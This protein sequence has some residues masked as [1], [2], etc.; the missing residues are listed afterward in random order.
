MTLTS[1]ARAQTVRVLGVAVDRE[2]VLGPSH[3]PQGHSDAAA[4]I[5]KY[6]KR[7]LDNPTARGCSGPKS[8]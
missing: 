6:T 8:K 7:H 5:L 2:E 3:G 4:H 1:R